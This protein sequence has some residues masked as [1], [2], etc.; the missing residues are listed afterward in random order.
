MRALALLLALPG[1]AQAADVEPAWAAAALAGADVP[2]PSNRVTTRGALALTLERDIWRRLGLRL[3]LHAS[4]AEIA[5]DLRVTAGATLRLLGWRGLRL[6]ATA[7]AGY[8]AIRVDKHDVALWTGALV[9]APG[10]ELGWSLSRLLELRAAPL[11]FSLFWNELWISA[12]APR[13]GL[14]L[15]W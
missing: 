7:E 5:T 12:W 6:R 15:R 4:R 14:A 3:A 2:I 13:L 11:A 10:I 1:L 8:A 9:L